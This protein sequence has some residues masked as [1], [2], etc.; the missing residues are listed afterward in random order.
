MHARID[1]GQVQ[2]LTWT[3][4]DWIAK[5]PT[6]GTALQ[7]VP[8]RQAYIDGE[9]CA[10]SETG[11]TSFSLMQAATDNRRTAAL[12]FYA[13]DLLYIDGENLTHERLV[14]RKRRLQRLLKGQ[15]SAVRYCDHQVGVGP[16]FYQQACHLALEGVVSK[17]LDAPY[18]PGNRG[19]WLKTKCVNREE[20]AV[21]RPRG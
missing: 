18:V 12:V 19:L 20:F 10:V 7:G 5:Y 4:L 1:H 11:V 17:R 3:G 15:G 13:F 6:T 14:E 9:L 8:A 2:L 21:D 16:L